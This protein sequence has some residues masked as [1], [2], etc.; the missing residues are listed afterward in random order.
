MA[1]QYGNLGNVHQTRGELEQAVQMYE[2]SLALNTELGRKEGM[3]AML[4]KLGLI[5]N[6]DHSA[7]TA[8]MDKASRS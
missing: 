1:N 6:S 2:K 4:G 8:I 5:T 7:A 3:A